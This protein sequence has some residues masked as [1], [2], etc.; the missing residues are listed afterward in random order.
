[1]DEKLLDSVLDYFHERIH[2]EVIPFNAK[3]DFPDT[4]EQEF[5]RVVRYLHNE[6][7][8]DMI[9]V[10][11]LARPENNIYRINE[12]GI[13]FKLSGGYGEST[14]KWKAQKDLKEEKENLELQQLRG[15]VELITNQL[16]DY[17]EVKTAARDANRI[18]VIAIIVTAIG[19]LLQWKGCMRG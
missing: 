12:Y 1:M 15:A 10:G 9:S 11:N 18:S 19:L 7:F 14:K 3:H 13:E 16:T 4:D 5:Y 6:P 2:K 17:A 8:L